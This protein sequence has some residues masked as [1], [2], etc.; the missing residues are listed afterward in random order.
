[1]K[2]IKKELTISL[3]EDKVSFNSSDFTL[4]E[5]LGISEYINLTCRM[6]LVDILKQKPKQA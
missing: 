1:M 6:Q 3:D 2:K 5:L 4:I